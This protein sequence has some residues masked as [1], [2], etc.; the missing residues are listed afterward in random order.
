V[1]GRIAFYNER[2][3]VEVDGAAEERPS[4]QWSR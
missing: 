2:T 4:T 3:D 1:R